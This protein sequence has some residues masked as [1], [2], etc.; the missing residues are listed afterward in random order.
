[1][2]QTL[3]LMSLALVA[4]FALGCSVER[5]WSAK[6]RREYPTLQEKIDAVCAAATPPS[7]EDL[8]RLVEKRMVHGAGVGKFRLFIKVGPMDIQMPERE[9]LAL[10]LQ[11]VPAFQAMVDAAQSAYPQAAKEP[12]HV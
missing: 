6:R 11:D 5:G 9:H 4:G 3:I 2:T 7:A 8:L 1:M 10:L 12:A